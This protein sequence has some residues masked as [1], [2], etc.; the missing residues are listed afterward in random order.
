MPLP[1]KS[2]KSTIT[3]VSLLL[4]GM[5]WNG[6]RAPVPVVISVMKLAP[7]V[8]FSH[9]RSDVPL[10][11][12][13]PRSTISSVSLLLSG[14]YWNGPR[15]PVLKAISVIKLEPVVV[16]SH[17]RSVVPLPSKSPSPTITS[18]SLLLSGIYWNGPRAPV[19]GVIS[20]IKLEPV[21]V[22]SHSR[23]VVP[24]PSK[25]G[26]SEPRSIVVVSSASIARQW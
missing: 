21:V 7:V 18:I 6:P 4:S 25:S 15:S 26:D 17:S 13:S 20:V 5:Y 1:S 16:F 24:L 2:P 14:M 22:F 12:K 10:P 23:S 3:S 19:L 9:S 8:V 11:S